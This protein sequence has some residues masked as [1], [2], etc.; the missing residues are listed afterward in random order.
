MKDFMITLACVPLI[1]VAILFMIPV[2]MIVHAA[3]FIGLGR[4]DDVRKALGPWEG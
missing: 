3:E 4:D 2:A 1:I